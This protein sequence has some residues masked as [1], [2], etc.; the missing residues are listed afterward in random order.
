MELTTYVASLESSSPYSQSQNIRSVPKDREQPD[1]FDTRCWRERM[2][3]SKDG[4]VYIPEMAFKNCL[5]SAAGK[6]GM[7]VK[8]KN[9]ATYKKVFEAGIM[10][11][12]PVQL[13]IKAEDVPPERVFVNSNGQRGGGT[14]VWRTFPLIEQWS[15]DLQIVVIDQLITEEV[16]REHLECAGLLI[17]IGRFRP[18]NRGFYGR[19][20]LKSLREE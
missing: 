9:R 1:A 7:K 4:N 2:H 10:I 19:F 15:G 16:L 13:D 6:L 11:V 12:H 5:D 14:R 17:G 8:G 18:E 3:I 20:K